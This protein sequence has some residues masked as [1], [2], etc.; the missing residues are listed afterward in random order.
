MSEK[1]KNNKSSRNK[2]RDEFFEKSKIHSLSEKRGISTRNLDSDTLANTYDRYSKTYRPSIN[3]KLPEQ[4]ASFGSAESY[5]KTAAENIVNYY[6]FDGTREEIIAWHRSSSVTDLAVYGQNW[7]S[8]VGSFSSNYNEYITFHAGPNKFSEAKYVGKVIK[9]ET[10]LNI[11]PATG[12]TIEFWMKKD[13]FNSGTYPTETIF[14]IGS[15]PSKLSDDKSGQ[16][17]LDLSSSAGSPFRLTYY[18]GQSGSQNLQIGSSNLTDSSVA[19]GLWHHYALKMW[20]SASNLYVKLYVDGQVDSTSTTSAGTMPIVNSFLG[21]AIASHQGATTGSFSGSLD[22]FRFWKGLRNSR[23]ITRFFD[24]KVYASDSSKESYSSR[25]GLNF[26]FN[27]SPIGLDSADS[28]VVDYSGNDI[29]GVINNYSSLSRKSESAIT[30]ASQSKNVEFGDAILDYAHPDVQSLTKEL[31]EIGQAHDLKNSGMLRN[32]LPE[33]AREH[34]NNSQYDTEFEIL[35]NLMTTEFDHVKTF[36]ESVREDRI[37]NYQETNFEIDQDALNSAS[38][39]EYKSNIFIGCRDDNVGNDVLNGN[40]VDMSMLYSQDFGLVHELFYQKASNTTDSIEG[41]IENLKYTQNLF[42]VRQAIARR[43]AVEAENLMKRKGTDSSIRSIYSISG[44]DNTEITDL[45][46]GAG[47]DLFLSDDKVEPYTSRIKSVNFLKNTSAT[48]FMSSSNSDELTYL[49]GNAGTSN[50]EYSFECSAV[51]PSSEVSSFE[52]AKTSLF[53]IRQVSGSNNDLTTFQ[54]D[55]AK[56]TVFVDKKNLNSKKARFILEADSIIPE[57]IS[58]SYINNVLDSSRWN[59]SVRVRKSTSEPFVNTENDKYEVVFSGY[60]YSLDNLVDSFELS[61]SITKQNYQN[62]NESN[63]TIFI[64]AIR[65]NVTGGV[66]NTCDSKILNFSAWNLSL[67]DEEVKQRAKSPLYYGSNNPHHSR[68]VNLGN[69]NNHSAIFRLQFSNLEDVSEENPFFTEDETSGSNDKIRSFGI[70]RG[71][72]YNFKS[73]GF[74]SSLPKVIQD[75]HISIVRPTPITSLKGLDEVSLKEKRYEKF[76]LSSRPEAKIYSFEKSVNQ[77]ISRDMYDFLCGVE[78]FNNIIGER[79]N[80]YRKEYKLLNHLRES[81]FSNVLNDTDFE[82]YLS[83]YR[84]IDSAI[85]VLWAQMIPGSSFSNTG[86]ENVVESHVL[87]RNKYQHKY[88]RVERKNPDIE[89]NLLAVN[90]LLYDWE[91][92]HAP[93][94]QDEDDNCL[95]QNDRKE[96]DSER[97]QIQRALTTNVSGSTYVLRNLTIPYKHTIERQDIISIGHN[98]KANKIKNL[99]KIINEGKEISVNSGDFYDFKKCDDVIDPQEEKIYV[100]KTNTSETNDYLDADAD[101]ILP[102]TFYSSSVGTDLSIFKQELKITNNLE[103][104][105]SVQSTLPRA[106]KSGP[107]H[108]MVEIGLTSS[109]ER[110]EAYMISASANSLVVKQS[111]NRKSMFHKGQIGGHVYHLGNIKTTAS[112]LLIGN[113]DKDYEIVMTNGRSLNN[114][115]LVENEGLNLTGTLQDSAYVSGNTDYQVPTRTRRE[116]VIV[117]RFSAPGSPESMSHFGLDRT[118]A[119]YSIYDT[120]NYRNSLVR[121]VYDSLSSERS[122]RFGYRSGSSTQASIHK[123]NRNLMRRTGSS[124]EEHTSDNLFIQRPI[125]QHDFGY[126]WI[127]ASAKESVYDFLNKNE[128]IGYSHGFAISGSAKSSET[129][130]FLSRSAV[131]SGEPALLSDTIFFGGEST[132]Y[133]KEFTPVDI[134]GLNTIVVDPVSSENN[135]LGV[136]FIEDDHLNTAFTNNYINSEINFGASPGVSGDNAYSSPSLALFGHA[137]TLNSIILNRQGPYGWPTWK[138][139]RGANHPIIRNQKKN[140]TMS[141]VY[142]NSLPFPSAYAGT[143]FDYSRTEEDHNIKKHVRITK[144]YIEMPA[145]CKFNPITVSMHTYR[146]NT[147][148]EFLA[149]VPLP[150]GFSQAKMAQMWFTDEFLH[151]FIIKMQNKLDTIMLPSLS[152]RAPIQNII[153]GFANQEMADEMYFKEMPFSKCKNLGIINDFIRNNARNPGASYLEINYIE[154]IYPREINTFTL[155]AR[156]RQAFDFFGWNSS[157]SERQLISTGNLEY[158]NL[159]HSGSGDGKHY[160]RKSNPNKNEISFNQ[161]YFDSFEFVDACNDSIFY[162]SAVVRNQYITASKWVLDSRQ[163]LTV[164]PINI[165]SSYFNLGNG[166]LS[167]H[168]D[169]SAIREQGIRGEGILQNDYSI[170]PLGINIL[171]GAPPF[172]PIYNRRIPQLYGADEFLAGEAKWEVTKSAPTGPFHDKYDTFIEEGRLVGQNYSLLPE[173]RISR[174]IEEIFSSGNFENPSVSTDFL[175][176]TG[177]VY[178]T[179][180]GDISIGKQF[181]KTYSNSDFMKYFQPFKNNLDENGFDIATGKLTLR[182]QAVKK[183][184]PYRGFYPAERS[185]QV[186]EIF[187]R[188]YLPSGSYDLGYISNSVISEQQSSDLISMKIENS[189][190]QVSKPLFQPGVL[191]NSIKSGLAVDYPIFSTNVSGAANHFVNSKISAPVTSFSAFGFNSDVCYTGSIINSTQDSG[192]PRISG[193]VERRVTFE[194]LLQPERLYLQKVYENEPHPSASLLY[195]D[196]QFLKVVDHEP[197]FGTLDEVNSARYNASNFRENFSSFQ[198]SLR[199]YR[200]A[201]NNFCA[202]TVRFFLQDERL[203]A[204]VSRPS[205]PRLESGVNYKMRV[206]INNKDVSMYDR[207]SAYG[208]PVDDGNA[209]VTNYAASS[210]TAGIAAGATIAFQG[211]MRNQLHDSGSASAGAEIVIED[212]EGT[213]IIY[214]FFSG[215]SNTTGDITVSSPL[216]IAV[217]LSDG[218]SISRPEASL[219]KVAINHANAHNGTIQVGIDVLTEPV[220]EFAI[221]YDRM[222]LTQSQTGVSGNNTITAPSGL[223]SYIS[224]FAGGTDEVVEPFLES[225]TGIESGSHGFLPYVPPYLDPYTSPYAELSFTPTESKNYTIPEILEGTSVSYYNM[226][227]PNNPDT[228][229]NYREAMVLSASLNLKNSVLLYSDNYMHFGTSG[230]STVIPNTKPDLFRWAIYPKWETPVLDFQR[231]EV[232]TLNLSNNQ[233]ESKSG[234]PWKRRYQ[235]EYYQPRAHDS[236]PYM[237]SSTGMW[238]QYGEGVGSDASKGYFLTIVGGQVKQG[239]Q[240]NLAEKVGFTDTVSSPSPGLQYMT[241]SPES[242]PNVEY[243]LGRVAKEKIISEAVVAIPYYLTDDCEIKLFPMKEQLNLMAIQYN[244]AQKLEYVEALRHASSEQEIENIRNEY[245]RFLESPGMTALDTAAYQ[246]RMM[247]KYI[248]PP[249]FD[250]TRNKDI[251]PHVSFIFQ[252]KAKLTSQDLSDIWQNTYPTKASGISKTQ[253]SEVSTDDKETDVEYVTHILSPGSVPFLKGQPSI[254]ESPED[255]LEKEVR[256]LV[257]KAKFRAE[258]NYSKLLESSISEIEDDVLQIGETRK[259]GNK[260]QTYLQGRETEEEQ[261]FSKYAYNWPYDYFSMVELV[262]IESKVDFLSNARTIQSNNPAPDTTLATN[263][264]GIPGLNPANVL[265]APQDVSDD[266]RVELSTAG[267]LFTNNIITNQLLKDNTSGLSVPNEVDITV[268]SGFSVKPGSEAVYVNGVLQSA[269]ADAD[270]TITSNKVTFNYDVATQDKIQVSY[271][272]QE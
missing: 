167:R 8:S 77:A 150:T 80:M 9:N 65:E 75:E 153:T 225:S 31:K 11:N 117:N 214:K 63:K 25:L 106:L 203:Q 247:D 61:S 1:K 183:L 4:F 139:I 204:V 64:G 118:A 260:L 13:G 211:V 95:W 134:L 46:L 79:V 105:S 107:A 223:S 271:I 218:A 5:Y 123:T 98:R 180:S 101:L 246:I 248:L 186:T 126:S 242:S 124:G 93:N 206:Y 33:W 87:E 91:H 103:V 149:D 66:T 108:R 142:R 85:G 89:T 70:L 19:D 224:G 251:E 131:G 113:Y 120:V 45:M 161:S 90:E 110:P 52:Y 129:I 37:P 57:N 51:F 212:H 268:D 202:E 2:R 114:N 258:S 143:K 226:T 209:Q 18:L 136:D 243:K 112:P 21:G 198:S 176:V 17:R 27:K 238:H 144:N 178:H 259:P 193:S 162:D 227:A 213:E 254:Y 42:E 28:L 205:K 168:A 245:D 122:E 181:F 215:S 6:P 217:E 132:S 16:I 233:V 41:I 207:H 160:F 100:A 20:H 49:T 252:F 199:P 43:C 235:T 50:G 185:V 83:Y 97:T 265:N 121:G 74:E 234:S 157:R 73:M 35:L 59:I 270:Y 189:K 140:N 172:A 84:W 38:S 216:T 210:S 104:P 68:Q 78:A 154:T 241:A 82:R 263:L 261:V 7:P 116:H 244:K 164:R 175:E 208:P 220:G 236:T 26:R 67:E 29:V 148:I 192:I 253:H 22:N 165:T 262:K 169:I 127:T 40:K 155:H 272:K 69:V 81:Y 119:E 32:L 201:I 264:S 190:T 72:K 267:A 237:T 135:T 156:Q 34:M 229:T 197:T 240:G 219:L 137:A 163:D 125:P 146:T 179:S 76:T 62:F 170:F 115:Y 14:D 55:Q 3:S 24:K 53:G 60:N 250:F 166:F 102:F 58:S 159:L 71:H 133:S 174:H 173:Y 99:Y 239:S 96:L 249:Q 145:T 86:I 184:L 182:C 92:G 269:G 200:S 15:Y 30:Q 255:F 232:S 141:V 177:A 48:L 256:W 128:N 39:I 187:H 230:D 196:R 151:E 231:A 23:E 191:F 147:G 158:N 10:G 221:S 130:L 94:P 36:L 188:N 47:S 257:F 12:S 109:L 56:M 228:N 194:D 195:G 266:F 88:N 171:R 152:M 44:I 54:T 111:P 138:Q 222:T